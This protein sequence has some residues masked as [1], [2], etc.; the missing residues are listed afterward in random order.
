LAGDLLRKKAGK[1][2]RNDQAEGRN[3][4]LYGQASH[5]WILRGAFGTP[6]LSSFNSKN[7]WAGREIPC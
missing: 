5:R 6:P 7:R 3:S 2:N 1:Q 4:D